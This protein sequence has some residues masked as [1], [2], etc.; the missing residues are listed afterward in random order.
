MKGNSKNSRVITTIGLLVILM[1]LLCNVWTLA[2]LRA[3]DAVQLPADRI[4][5]W[6][7]DVLCILGGALLIIYRRRIALLNLV[8]VSVVV[9]V[10]FLA[11]EQATRVYLF[12][13]GSFNFFKMNSI[14]H[15]GDSGLIRPSAYPK[16]I[17]ELKPN[18]D[19]YFKMARFKT[20]SQ[21]LRDKEY[22]LEKPP[23]T[24]R[25]AVLGDSSS[26]PAGVDIEDAY[27]TV[28]E[29]R[30]NAESS[31]TSYEFINFAV[32][33]YDP[34]QYLAT[35][36]HKALNYDPDLVLFCMCAP[37]ENF[38]NKEHY[39]QQYKVKPRSYPFFKS[40]FLGRIKNGINP[41]FKNKSGKPRVEPEKT[42]S[43]GPTALQKTR[44][45]FSKL[46]KISRARDIP[47]CVVILQHFAGQ[48]KVH[49]IVKDSASKYGLY[50]TS[51]YPAFKNRRFS[52]YVIYKTDGHANAKAN[53]IFADVIYDY[54]K[55]QDLI[56]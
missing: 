47:V 31:G 54:L 37:V 39:Q 30:L 25:V 9:V 21:G 44:M 22:S 46:G 10:T 45:V 3:D 34:K 6:S 50:I 53:K 15:M 52:Q 7:F 33:G 4:L 36:K 5:I 28:L 13:L 26:M 20:N 40:F 32:A 29:D 11:L 8:K 49:K 1:P 43:S 23:N 12:G 35:L 18:M 27:H 51:T 41:Y 24:F 55:T 16:L 48:P 38:H 19:V 17:Y 56:D 2:L 42:D 14:H